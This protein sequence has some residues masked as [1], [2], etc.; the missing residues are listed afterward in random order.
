MVS[1]F[2]D[3][4]SNKVVD[5]GEVSIGSGTFDQDNGSLILQMATPYTLKPGKND[6]LVTFDF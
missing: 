2:I 5:T 1:L 4:N 6:L 3:A